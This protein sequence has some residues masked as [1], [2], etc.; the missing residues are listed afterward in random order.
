MADHDRGLTT[1]LE[2]L[3]ERGQAAARPQPAA[4][5]RAT[6]DRQTRRHRVL[7]AAALV[8]VVAGGS[9][10]MTSGGQPTRSENVRTPA[11]P[12]HGP[13]PTQLATAP[14]DG[15]SEPRTITDDMVV[16]AGEV[17]STLGTMWDWKLTESGDGSSALTPCQSSPSADPDRQAARTA[18]VTGGW[19]GDDTLSQLVEQSR[20][21]EASR[22]AYQAAVQW[23]TDCGGTGV[24]QSNARHSLARRAALRPAIDGVD[25]MRIIV[26]RRDALSD[27][28]GFTNT[29]AAVI[30]ADNLV[31]VLAW[32]VTI[33]DD[34]GVYDDGFIELARLVG[35]RLV[36]AEVRV[37][38]VPEHVPQSIPDSAL[39]SPDD[40]TI[41]DAFGDTQGSVVANAQVPRLDP[42]CRRGYA[43]PAAGTVAVRT[44]Q[45]VGDGTTA[46]L[47]EFVTR[48]DSERSAEAAV[49]TAANA[50]G[51]CPTADKIDGSR[52]NID[53]RAPEVDTV[54]AWGGTFQE[55]G[56]TN[57]HRAV[58][59]DGDLVAY[60]LIDS[61][62]RNVTDSQAQ[63]IVETAAQRL[64]AATL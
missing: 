59:R 38:P 15:S 41:R 18:V 51:R 22:A 32:D 23:F 63:A 21:A 58:V 30:R 14:S 49:S 36:G 56:P 13:A 60:L 11:A 53:V 62:N 37:G 3:S 54:L 29:V 40:P 52:R 35:R 17:A 8:L 7:L 20:D 28:I 16:T 50:V 2:R 26:R 19:S 31:T 6:A 42:L 46:I 55:A 45:I 12:S 25:D 27:G 61:A 33:D 4:F 43:P 44:P 48:Y 47:L 9:A 57:R 1:V 64:H 39:L 10:L 5:V 34:P 24:D